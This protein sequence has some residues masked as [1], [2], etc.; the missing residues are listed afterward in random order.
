MEQFHDPATRLLS[1][2]AF[3]STLLMGYAVESLREAKRLIPWAFQAAFSRLPRLPG[4][5]RNL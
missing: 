3:G 1:Y 2:P 4:P 5:L